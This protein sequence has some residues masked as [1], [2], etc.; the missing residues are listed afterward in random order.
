MPVSYQDVERL[1]YT[2]GAF[3]QAPVARCEA[4]EHRF[5]ST[6]GCSS[7]ITAYIFNFYLEFNEQHA[8]QL[9]HLLWTLCFLKT[10]MTYDVLC[11]WFGIGCHKTLKKWV[12]RVIEVLW[13]ID[14]VV[15]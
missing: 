13:V 8:F 2:M 15:S 5:H 12:W 14:D 1:V 6:F 7:R 9:I 3:N 10:Y 11:N 4:E